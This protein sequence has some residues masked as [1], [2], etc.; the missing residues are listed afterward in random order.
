M[1]DFEREYFEE[2]P[3]AKRGGY[4]VVEAWT[5]RFFLSLLRHLEKSKIEYKNGKGKRALDIGCA[6]GYVLE[7]L[8]DFG[9]EIYGM[10]ISKYAIKK[11]KERLPQGTFSVYDIQKGVPFKTKFDFITCIETLEHLRNPEISIKNCYGALNPNGVFLAS[12]P[13]KRY[14]QRYVPLLPHTEDETHVNVRTAEEW[15]RCFGVFKWRMQKVVPL[16]S[17]PLV[18]RFGK[19]FRFQFSLGET[20]FIVCVK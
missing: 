17:V 8:S 15:E 11:A 3:Y 20:V 14:W 9:Y 2:G 13:H 4:E 7:V 6:Y 10:D 12:T 1:V 16:Q 5:K 19:Y 18:W